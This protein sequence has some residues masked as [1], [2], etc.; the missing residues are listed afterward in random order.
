MN[1]LNLLISLLFLAATANAG[2]VKISG[3]VVTYTIAVEPNTPAVEKETGVKVTAKSSNAGKGMADLNDGHIDIAMAA[4]TLE[5]M[6]KAGTGAGSNI[7][8]NQF[9]LHPLKE[10]EFNVIVNKAN[11]V[12]KLTRQQLKDILTGKISN[13][14]DVGGSDSP[15]MVYTDSNSGGT[16]AYL[17][18]KVMNNEEFGTNRK[19]TDTI[20]KL[21]PGVGSFPNAISTVISAHL[22]DKVKKVT[23]EGDKL[24]RSMGLITKG[25]PKPEVEKVIKAFQAKMK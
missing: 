18:S 10:I 4:D 3:A 19:M 9:Q 1:K 7:D 15:I 6:A 23:L 2:E 21:A 25:A 14:K 20:E 8:I 17:K 13:W 12:T 16:S 5:V 11:P 24:T 22:N